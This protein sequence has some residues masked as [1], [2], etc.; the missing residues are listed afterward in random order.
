MTK[1]ASEKVVIESPTSFAG[2]A[3]RIWKITGD[4][5]GPAKIALGAVAVVLIGM[6]WC[7]VLCWYLIWGIFII[8]WR[9]IRRGGRKRKRDA[10]RHRELLAAQQRTMATPTPPMA[11]PPPPPPPPN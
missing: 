10:L 9:L 2:S 3:K 5:D 11:P 1:L 7:L 6:V 4:N 8:P